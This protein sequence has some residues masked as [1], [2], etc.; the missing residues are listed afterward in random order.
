[1]TVSL[2]KAL[3][4]PLVYQALFTMIY[5]N[6]NNKKKKQYKIHSNKRNCLNANHTADWTVCDFCQYFH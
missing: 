5:T 1:M 6:K 4:K 2:I 3:L